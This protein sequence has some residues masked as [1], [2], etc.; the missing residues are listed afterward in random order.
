MSATSSC[1]V[2]SDSSRT[3]A[4]TKHKNQNQIFSSFLSLFAFQNDEAANAFTLDRIWHSYDGRLGHALR[5]QQSTE[6]REE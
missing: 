4:A 5:Q 1:V 6:K 2:S 3:C